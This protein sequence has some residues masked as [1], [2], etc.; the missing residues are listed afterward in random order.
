MFVKRVEPD[1]LIQGAILAAATAFEAKL[2]EKEREYR[3]TIATMPKVIET[4]RRII[5]EMF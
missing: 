2:A 3:A 5:Q 4:E 1:L